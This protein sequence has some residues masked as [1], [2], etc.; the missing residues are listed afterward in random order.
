L[1]TKTVKNNNKGTELAPNQYYIE[2]NYNLIIMLI[3]Y[4]NYHHI[5]AELL[6]LVVVFRKDEDK[7][8]MLLLFASLHPAFDLIDN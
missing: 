7:N 2:L 5:S 1:I 3:N 6:L 8:R 4:D